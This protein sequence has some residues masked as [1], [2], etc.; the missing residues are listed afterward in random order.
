MAKVCNGCKTMA[1]E[2]E[3][4]PYSVLKDFKETAKT[5]TRRWF[6]VCLVLI[7]LFVGSN[8]AWFVY[9]S[10]YQNIE[11]TEHCELDAGDGGNAIINES[12]C[13]RVGESNIYQNNKSES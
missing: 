9:E 11:I 2:P 7:F 3:L 4:V 12:G 10:Q 1:A 5:N 13:V 8:V 6:V